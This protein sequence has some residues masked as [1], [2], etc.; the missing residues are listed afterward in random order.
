MRCLHSFH[1]FALNLFANLATAYAEEAIPLSEILKPSAEATASSGADPNFSVIVFNTLL[2]LGLGIL[3]MR[4]VWFID[5]AERVKQGHL[6]EG[7]PVLIAMWQAIHFS[8]TK[9]LKAPPTQPLNPWQASSISLGSD[10]TPSW[11]ERLDVQTLETGTKVHWMRVHGQDYLLTETTHHSQ[12]M[13][14]GDNAE[15]REATPVVAE[16]AYRLSK[17]EEAAPRQLPDYLDSL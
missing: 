4:Q 12:W 16:E 5:W 10:D 3:V 14:L 7:K 6:Q 15:E 2:V 13:K 9:A 17:L 11:L 8:W 1:L